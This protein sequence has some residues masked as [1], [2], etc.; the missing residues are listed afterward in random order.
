MIAVHKLAIT[1]TLNVNYVN[2]ISLIEL[3][4]KVTQVHSTLHPWVGRTLECNHVS[5]L[6]CLWDIQRVMACSWNLVIGHSR[7]LKMAE[8]DRAHIRSCSSF[9]VTIATSCIVS[10][11]KRH[12]LTGWKARFSSYGL[13]HND[14]WGKRCEYF[15]AVI[16]TTEPDPSLKTT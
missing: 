4:L 13:L 8:F 10:E 14:P 7:S 5:I 1:V 3:P 12:R 11:I 15:R 16:F 2:F 9:I 6:Y